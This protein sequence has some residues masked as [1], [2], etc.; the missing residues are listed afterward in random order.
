MWLWPP[1]SGGN[2]SLSLLFLLPFLP[3]CDFEMCDLGC[4]DP[5]RKSRK[6]FGLQEPCKTARMGRW[7]EGQGT[8]SPLLLAGGE[9]SLPGICG[10]TQ[11]AIFRD[12]P[13][14]G[15]STRRRESIGTCSLPAVAQTFQSG[16]CASHSQAV[17]RPPC[18]HS[19]GHAVGQRPGRWL[20]ARDTA[21]PCLPSHPVE[22]SRWGETLAACVL[23][24]T[25]DLGLLRKGGC[26][27]SLSGWS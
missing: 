22:M 5:E 4:L 18:R 14:L 2:L 21:P 27:G 24:C 11:E 23:L 8:R 7:E 12:S 9:E 19:A 13:A 3:L 6:S 16:I 10:W 26:R 15:R 25:G 1:I 17:S 20:L